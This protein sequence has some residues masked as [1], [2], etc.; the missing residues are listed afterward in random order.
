MFTMKR[1]SQSA[2]RGS[3][4]SMEPMRHAHVD[5]SQDLDGEPVVFACSTWMPSRSP[6]RR[7]RSPWLRP[8]AIAAR[9]CRPTTCSSSRE[10]TPSP[11]SSV[12]SFPACGRWS[13]A[14][15]GSR[16]I[17]TRLP[18]SWIPATRRSGSARIVSRSPSWGP[19]AGSRAASRRGR[20][21]GAPLGRTKLAQR[22]VVTDASG[23][24]PRDPP[25]ERA[26]RRAALE[27]PGAAAARGVDGVAA[28]R[29]AFGQGDHEI[30]VVA[31]AHA[32]FGKV[33]RD[34]LGPTGQRGPQ[35]ALVAGGDGGERLVERV[36]APGS[37][38]P[39]GAGSVR[40]W[41]GW[42]GLRLDEAVASA[43]PAGR[44]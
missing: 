19:S 7:T 36:G 4:P 26:G 33:G 1:V 37:P 15:R 6:R 5:I 30:A 27:P 11:T 17:A 8:S 42:A 2:T 3:L 16:S 32:H 39:R 20:A 21:G 41:P 22:S 40:C 18:S 44:W 25:S 10:P 34:Q 28:N 14:R 38:L 9:R 35:L 23:C 31:G 29:P 13:C 43:G 24:D 12:R